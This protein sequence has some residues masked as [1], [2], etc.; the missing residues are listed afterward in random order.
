MDVW[1]KRETDVMLDIWRIH[2]GK[3]EKVMTWGKGNGS[4]EGEVKRQEGNAKK[5][6]KEWRGNVTAVNE[7]KMEI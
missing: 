2:E 1:K 7:T 6:I 5:H 4:R 3:R